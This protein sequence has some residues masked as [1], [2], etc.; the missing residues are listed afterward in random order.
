MFVLDMG[1][2]QSLACCEKKTTQIV[3]VMWNVFKM[4]IMTD[5]GQ[6]RLKHIKE[7]CSTYCD[8]SVAPCQI[9]AVN[10][11]ATKS[12]IAKKLM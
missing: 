6:Y 2:Y 7:I 9:C 4:I 10:R 11:D 1:V 5:Y 8:V 12:P 3:H